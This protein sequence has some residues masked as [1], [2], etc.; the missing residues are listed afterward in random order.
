MVLKWKEGK[1]GK[2]QFPLGGEGFPPIV[3]EGVIV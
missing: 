2:F 1:R 3:V